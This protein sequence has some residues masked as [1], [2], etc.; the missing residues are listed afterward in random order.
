M[1]EKYGGAHLAQTL[2]S[3]K[4]VVDDPS[5]TNVRGAYEESC[6]S[7]FPY[8]EAINVFT[9]PSLEACRPKPFVRLL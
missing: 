7:M 8:P 2:V 9:P 6:E 1:K 5:G 4:M 3:S